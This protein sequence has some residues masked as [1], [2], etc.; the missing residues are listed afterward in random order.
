MPT[1]LAPIADAEIA[2]GVER[3]IQKFA[4]LAK[5]PT[6]DKWSEVY[7]PAKQAVKELYDL[8]PEQWDW[9]IEQLTEATE[10]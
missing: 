10:I 4:H 6:L 1:A 7:E 2:A 8:T 5:D 3:V 9:F